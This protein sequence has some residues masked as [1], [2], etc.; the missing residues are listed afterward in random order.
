M[1]K[2]MPYLKLAV[3]KNASDIF[4]TTNSPAM[5]K[6]E[7]EMLAIGK[8]QMTAEFIQ[9][10]ALSILTEEQKSFLRMNLEIDLAIQAA[11][12]ARF[13]VNIFNQRGNHS[14]VLRYVKS[15][16]PRLENLNVPEVLTRSNS[17]TPTGARL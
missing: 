14:M 10:L 9:E 4:F 13:R 3:D 6:V 7:G 11:G 12:L 1:Q 5:L 16:V 15:E 17:R 8:T 2:L